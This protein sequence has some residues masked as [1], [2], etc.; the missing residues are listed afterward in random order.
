[1]AEAAA[2]MAAADEL[3]EISLPGCPRAQPDGATGYLARKEEGPPER[4]FQA[5]QRFELGRHPGS[6]Y[7]MKGA[8]RAGLEPAS[9][10]VTT[11]CSAS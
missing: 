10:R 11:G 5:T 6:E 1:M 7:A 8:P 3:P 9:S 2:A 4:A